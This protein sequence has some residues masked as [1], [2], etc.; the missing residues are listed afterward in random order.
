MDCRHFRMVSSRFSG[1]KSLAH[2]RRIAFLFQIP[3][4][5]FSG[6]MIYL[7]VRLVHKPTT[8]PSSGNAS[9]LP[10]SS[11][12]AIKPSVWKT[13]GRI[14]SLGSLLL[15]TTVGSLLLALSFKT[16]ST[17]ARELAW[18]DP[19]VWSLLATS[20]VG[21]ILFIFVEGWVAPEPVLPLRLLTRRTPVAVAIS[22]FTFSVST[23]SV[24]RL[25]LPIRTEN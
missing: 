11:G 3:F 20:G 8:A 2:S 10:T 14:D 22:N 23:F 17:D 9:S 15:V 19:Q 1:R 18:S 24:V 25:S 12:Q 13:L 7:K 4:L 21:F 6:I 16:A 5:L